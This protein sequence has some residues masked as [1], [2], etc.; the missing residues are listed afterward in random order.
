MSYLKKMLSISCVFAAVSANAIVD[1]ASAESAIDGGALAALQVELVNNVSAVNTSVDVLNENVQDLTT[2]L[3]ESDITAR[4]IQDSASAEMGQGKFGGN[5]AGG[6][7]SIRQLAERA[8][9]IKLIA[10]GQISNDLPSISSILENIVTTSESLTNASDASLA[11]NAVVDIIEEATLHIEGMKTDKSAIANGD[12]AVAADAALD[13]ADK[14]IVAAYVVL[15]HATASK[16]TLIAREALK[17]AITSV[18]SGDM[19]LGDLLTKIKPDASVALVGSRA[20]VDVVTSTVNSHQSNIIANSGNFGLKRHTGVNAGDPNLNMGVWLKAFGS[21]S[22]MDT[23]DSIVGYEANVHGVL[24]GVDQ[25][26]DNSVMFGLAMSFA[27]VDV[28]GSSNAKSETN[29]NQYQGTLYG[30]LLLD[31]F[32]IN[33]SVAYARSENHTERIGF[34]GKISGDYNTETTSA[35]LGAGVPID[36]GSFAVTPQI[37]TSYSRVVP[38]SYTENGIGSLNVNTAS[39]DLF[40]VK[41]G[42]VTNAKTQ[43]EKSALV[44]KL[45]LFADWDIAKDQTEVS[46]SW[47][48]TGTPLAVTVGPEPAALGG[49]FGAGIDYA[50]ND[51]VY[52][53]SLDY[54]LGVK[55]D[56]V[57]HAASVKFRMNF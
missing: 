38:D 13:A 16:D 12:N 54:D 26:I 27:D 28:N 21:D 55:S 18:D 36:M 23:H 4:D 56:F 33:G 43:F 17:S 22:T 7:L 39:V 15:D 57:S 8:Q 41:A 53:L 2:V 14:V 49:V 37:S 5:V 11:I 45:R 19:A 42:I 34:G 51:G 1:I 48:S 9:R 10:R 47:V 35:S 29:I 40:G 50:T 44:S 20:A 52:I 46:S 31:S 25:T 6:Q 3:D 24:I 30:A 32:F